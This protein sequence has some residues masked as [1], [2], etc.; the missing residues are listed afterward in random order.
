MKT[1]LKIHVS[2]LPKLLCAAEWIDL[3][4]D[5]ENRKK[6]GND[7]LLTVSSRD[8]SKL[9]ELGRMME[10]IPTEDVQRF[11]NEKEAAA[12]AAAAK[13]TTAKTAAKK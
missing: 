1:K 13:E 10:K 2:E 4:V 5:T 11:M 3:T 8:N 7:V 12:K 9:V 6:L